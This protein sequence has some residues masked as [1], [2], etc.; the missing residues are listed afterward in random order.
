MIL[1]HFKIILL[2]WKG[3][4]TIYLIRILIKIL[5]TAIW[6]KG[7]IVWNKNKI[8]LKLIKIK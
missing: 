6:K 5:I 2:M 1:S 7:L 8:K 3:N 4:K